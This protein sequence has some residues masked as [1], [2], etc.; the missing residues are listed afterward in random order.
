GNGMIA[1]SFASYKNNESIIIFASG[2]SNSK[3]TV[4][5]HY[6]REFGLLKQTIQDY[7]E[8]TLVYFSTCSIQDVDL[9]SLP[10]VIHKKNI[11]EYISKNAEKYYLFRISNLAGVSN[12]PYTLLN[13]FIFNILKD[14]PLTV[15][16]NA[17]RNIIGVDDMY[18]IVNYFL[19]QKENINTLINIANPQNYSVRYIIKSIETHLNKKAI[20][21]EVERGDNYDIDVRS[22]EPL[23]AT[24]NIQFN[25]N[26]LASL[27]KKY[28][29]SR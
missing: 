29:H 12:N 4:E 14:Q 6:Q 3:D 24:L 13:Y 8:K 2:V 28:Y 7:P 27:L 11:E 16:K 22:I 9:A 5:E 19:Q 15:W 10:Y 23:F 17:F 25:D 18:A 26:Y 1:N 21:N 20:I